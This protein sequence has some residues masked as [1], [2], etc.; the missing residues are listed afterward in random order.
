LDKVVELHPGVP[1]KRFMHQY[2]VSNTGWI[3]IQ[4][5]NLTI[6][7]QTDIDSIIVTQVTVQ[8]KG[9]KD[10][11]RCSSVV[12]SENNSGDGQN[13]SENRENNSED[14]GNNSQDKENNSQADEDSM[15]ESEESKENNKNNIGDVEKNRQ[16]RWNRTEKKETKH[17]CEFGKL[18]EEESL[19]L[20]IYFVVRN[21]DNS[22]FQADFAA[23]VRSSVVATFPSSLTSESKIGECQ[24]IVTPHR[25]TLVQKILQS[26]DL[27]LGMVIGLILVILTGLVMHRL[28]VFSRVRLYREELEAAAITRTENTPSAFRYDREEEVDDLALSDQQENSM[29][30]VKAKDLEVDAVT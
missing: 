21:I 14:G 3:P 26:W 4:Q 10:F 28:G 25:P 30:K 11:T 9:N 5:I 20:E 15:Q 16:A 1:Q 12:Q 27:I 22:S 2:E 18:A 8:Y 23:Q 24:T 13:N 7:V 29:D 6:T 17:F 19:I